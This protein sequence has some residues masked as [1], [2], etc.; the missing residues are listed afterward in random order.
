MLVI[1]KATIQR[2]MKSFSKRGKKVR[3]W[4]KRTLK[5]MTV[6]PLPIVMLLSGCADTLIEN[7]CPPPVNLDPRVVQHLADNPEPSFMWQEKVRDVAV[8][9][10]LK[11]C[12]KEAGL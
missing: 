6:F 5:L 2:K 8:M 1:T 3:S 7:K 10:K 4:I 11:I 9:D 12:R